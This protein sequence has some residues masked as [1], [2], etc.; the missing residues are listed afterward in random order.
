MRHYVVNRQSR[1]D[2]RYTWV[3][4]MASQGVPREEMHIC[5]AM[6]KDDYPTPEA[7][8]H[9]AIADGF[10]GFFQY[11]LEHPHYLVGLGHL[12]CSWSVMRMWR[13]IAHGHETAVAWLDDYALRVKVSRLTSL[14]ERLNPDV[15]MLAWHYRRDLF[16]QQTTIPMADSFCSVPEPQSCPRAPE[17]YLGAYGGSDWANVLS[18]RGAQ[19]ILDYMEA[20]PFL[21]TENAISGMWRTFP[22]RQTV[23]A[24]RGNN[25]FSHGMEILRGNQ[26]IFDLSAYLDGPK[27]DLVGLHQQ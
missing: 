18:P 2:R 20:Y 19:W 26:W 23:Y 16:G 3:G 11:H 17:V 15:L 10:R 14:V 12:I 6:D 1:N 13:E 25:P 22:A 5:L 9:A 8:C 21:N 4:A 7:I 27:S 24:A